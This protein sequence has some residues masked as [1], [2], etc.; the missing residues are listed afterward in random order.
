MAQDESSMKRSTAEDHGHRQVDMILM[1][2]LSLFSGLV[3]AWS[4]DSSLSLFPY[5][6]GDAA[7][8]T[9]LVA[10]NNHQTRT[11][12]GLAQVM[13]GRKDPYLCAHKV[14]IMF[15]SPF[16]FTPPLFLSS[17]LHSHA[18]QLPPPGALYRISLCNSIAPPPPRGAPPTNTDT[19]P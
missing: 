17:C 5:F 19:T 1:L 8:S 12:R 14:F 9:Q 11:V 7:S 13:K 10:L 18:F 15:P 3:H 16:S 6:Q 2:A 4:A